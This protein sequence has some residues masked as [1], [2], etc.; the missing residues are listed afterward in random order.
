[1]SYSER[2]QALRQCD[3]AAER[4][5]DQV[6]PGPFGRADFVGQPRVTQIGPAGFRVDGAMRVS[7]RYRSDIIPVGCTIRRG[8]VVDLDFNPASIRNDHYWRHSSRH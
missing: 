1:M 5:T 3:F 6:F 4:R 2:S 7:G 8:N